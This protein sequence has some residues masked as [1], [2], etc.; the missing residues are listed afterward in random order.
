MNDP[1]LLMS[2][3]WPWQ[4]LI[5][6]TNFG[7]ALFQQT[8]ATR[9]PCQMLCLNGSKLNFTVGQFLTAQFKTFLSSLQG[10]QCNGCKEGMFAF[11]HSWLVAEFDVYHQSWMNRTSCNE[12]CI[13]A[14]PVKSYLGCA[15]SIPVFVP[16]LPWLRALQAELL[17][18]MEPKQ[19]M[20]SL[21]LNL[22]LKAW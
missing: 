1:S 22:I 12:C 7:M 8:D 21:K 6:L 15:S 13:V 20:S 5:I 17:F 18:W 10:E 11:G 3:S 19:E 14:K 2:S 9:S 16:L 4:Q